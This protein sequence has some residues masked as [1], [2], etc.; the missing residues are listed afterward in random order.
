MINFLRYLQLDKLSFWA[1]FL[2]ASLF[3]WLWGILRP[4]ARRLRDWLKKSIQS[5]RQGLKTGAE[6]RQRA[7]TLKYAQGLHLAAPLFSLDEI[8]IPP[9]LLAPPPLV[10]PDEHPP[11]E[12]IVSMTIPYT[13]DWPELAAVYGAHPLTIF[14]ALQGGANL[15]IIGH[16]GSGKTTTLAYLASQI[17]RQDPAG[18]DLRNHIPVLVH[19]SDLALP[20]KNPDAIID[21][22][23][24]AI[25][26]RASTLSLP[27]LPELLRT[28][29]AS[30]Q[31]ILLLDGLDELAPDSLQKAVTFLGDLLREYPQTR[32]VVAAAVDNFDG[33]PIL[34]LVPI[35]MAV[36]GPR[37][38]AIFIQQWSDLWDRFIADE[39]QPESDNI[40]PLLLNGWLLNM[41][42]AATP[43]EFT[44][45]VWSVYA[46][47]A[48]GPKSSDA[49]E[50]YIRRM[51]VGVPKARAALEQLASQVVF[52]M[53]TAFTQREAKNLISGADAAS[54]EDELEP[55]VAAEPE[56]SIKPQE[57]AIP[58][59]LPD[60]AQHGLL[61]T[62][63]NSQLG[64]VHPLITGYLA[65][66]ALAQTGGKGV[67]T[68]PSWLLRDLAIQYLVSHIDLSEQVQQLLAETTDPVQRG[69]L[70]AGR[71]LQNIPPGA[72]LRKP[73]LQHLSN[74]L[75]KE[76]LSLGLRIRILA[77]LATSGDPGVP[78]LF[79]HL[80]KSKQ[81]SVRQL[82]ALGC[83]FTRD[84][85]SV[86][87]MVKLLGDVPEVGRA[88]CLAL[89]NI[90]TRPALEAVASALLQGEEELRRA[91]AE[92]FANHPEEGHPTL[93]EGA[94]IDDLLVRRAVIYGLLRIRQPWSVQILEEM[95]IEDAQ[96][97]VKDAAARAVEELNSP[98][99]RIPRQLPPLEDTPWL[100]A[101]ASERGVGISA[102]E[103][104]REML[105]RALRDGNEDEQLAAIGQLQQRGE[106]GIFPA[107]YHLL[108]GSNPELSEA[109]FNIVW[110]IAATGVDF[111]PPIQFGLG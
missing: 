9:R 110:H 53:Q 7:D 61:V 70:T 100:I 66:A 46:G 47:D 36:W 27:R 56:E 31:A 63:A 65:G 80:L 75:Q 20:P 34:G 38:Q 39:I 103:S 107:I 48:R 68:Q 33:L 69:S 14:E 89:V 28:S 94:G 21:T 18:G 101:F 52:T 37:E 17:A 23:I 83:G 58:G 22:L 97:V 84:I 19:V 44:L 90:R 81:S 12:D 111:P 59:V 15:A 3:W 85:Q 55:Y 72:A 6:Q 109:A 5:A 64:F 78:T 4:Y 87:E 88:V 82:A 41:N 86:G 108:Y 67:F 62:R 13:P 35:P 91:A 57:T 92:A 79:H 77:A 10:E 2:A 104:A 51:S 99:P 26:A 45:Q 73:I 40:D 71:W 95:R 16:P 105:L 32:V 24:D 76:S 54:E 93:K 102:G 1:G 74:S 42:A 98:D 25:A 96:W 106:T 8:L 49:I 43:L 30:G 29:F 11:S 50:A 60:L